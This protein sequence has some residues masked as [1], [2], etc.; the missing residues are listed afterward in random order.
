MKTQKAMLGL[1]AVAIFGYALPRPALAQ[2]ERATPVEERGY[3]DREAATPG[4]DQFTGGCC[5]EIP[6][7]I[8]P[9]IILLAP[10]ALPIYGL[11][12]LGEATGDCVK[13]T[14]SSPPERKPEAP[15]PPPVETPRTYPA[16]VGAAR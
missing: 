11:I 14:F 15:R 9:F 1:M 16:P 5:H 10:V 7:W 12:K 3:A 13:S 6:W 4:L 8:I 2:G